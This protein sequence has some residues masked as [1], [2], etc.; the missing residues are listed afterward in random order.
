MERYDIGFAVKGLQ[1]DLEHIDIEAHN[2]I[3]AA[4]IASAMEI[5]GQ[6]WV[7]SIYWYC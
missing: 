3:E 5:E 2:I 1:A 6:K 4:Q 7:V